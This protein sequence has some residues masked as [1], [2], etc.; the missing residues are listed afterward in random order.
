MSFWSA[1]VKLITETT[2]FLASTLPKPVLWQL[3]RFVAF[4]WWDVFRFRRFTIYRNLTIVFPTASKE[5]RKRIAKESLIWM[6]YNFFE[7]MQIPSFTQE[8][9]QEQ[10]RFE[11]LENFMKAKAQGKGVLL[12]C[13]HIGNGDAA[14]A[15]MSLSG[16]DMSLITKRF[17]NKTFNDVW[18]WLRS[19][20][21][22]KFINAHGRETS[23]RILK[24]LKNNGSVAFVQD[25]FMGKPFGIASTFFGKTTGTAYGLA[26]FA[27]KT[28][29]PVITASTFRDD[30]FKTVI[31]FGEEINVEVG[32][33]NSQDKDL[34]MLRMTEKYNRALEKIILAHP[35]QWMWVHR[36]WKKFE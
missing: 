32:L 11:G 33:Q 28:G 18:F 20:N 30:Q 1:L 10:V 3:G 13:L 36:R 26:L 15:Y 4:L 35:E 25:Q 23:F 31:Q 22:T 8:D 2:S 12:L 21:G 34:Q 27:A 6:G 29:A 5:E 9:L 24:A 17:K 7:I 19:R 16:M 14:V